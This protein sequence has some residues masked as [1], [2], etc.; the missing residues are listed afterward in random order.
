MR[1]LAILAAITLI[2]AST[3][4][5]L[6]TGAAIAG[7]GK[8]AR[9]VRDAQAGVH[10]LKVTPPQQADT[11]V[12]PSI[13]VNPNNPRNAVAVFQAGRVD[14]GCAQTIGYAT[15]FDGGKTW[16]DGSLPKISK[17]TGGTTPLVSDPVVAFGPKS[18]V[19]VNV[20]MCE[21]DQNDL[22]F[23]VSKNG[24]RTWNKPIRVPTERTLP[25]DDKNWIVVDNGKG[26]GHHPGRVYLVWDNIAPVVAMYSDDQAKTW[27]GPFV[28]YGG[29]GIGTIPLVL[30][31]G[32]LA[33]VF[34]TLA[35]PAPPI[36]DGP[37]PPDGGTVTRPFK[38]LISV[39]AGAGLVPTGGPL[40]FSPPVTVAA[41][42]GRD[43]RQQRAG[44]G[45][46]TADVDP[47][48]GRIYVAWSDNRFR[49][50]IVNDIVL[51]HSDNGV[52][53]SEP[54]RINPGARD[55]YLE[56]FTPALAV[57]K[58]GIVRVSYRTQQQA[59]SITRFSPYVDTYYQQSTNNGR[60][61]SKPLKVN[62]RVRTDV[63][64]A[65]FS[66]NSAFLGDYS[67]IAVTGSW[68]YIVRCEAFRL[69]KS[70]RA[71]FPPA[72]HHQRAWVAVVDAD[73]D[74]RR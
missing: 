24:G 28:V 68:A 39:A 73:G 33:V 29:Q 7:R 44:E 5:S 69:K 72:V 56:H 8:G 13:S 53:W 1:R 70:E 65:A 6:S 40:T 10:K 62:K 26:L 18:V 42:F 59:P 41:D 20:L 17:A 50:D 67:Q 55:D 12:E 63:R 66:R 22:A 34:N 23:S 52:S 71:I 35:W 14:A 3:V 64:F 45:L 58:D 60:T 54:K 11:A 27:H 61:F 25:F 51:V 49:K 36:P 32:D 19:Y 47:K 46:P 4:G 9:V 21:D 74:G 15:T 43:V 16:R 2:S 38:Y 48:T 31:S 57:G 37:R 30:P